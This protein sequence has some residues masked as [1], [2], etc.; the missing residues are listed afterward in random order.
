MTGSGNNRADGAVSSLPL[1][2]RRRGTLE[3]APAP[4]AETGTSVSRPWT[5]VRH[6]E[7]NYVQT[8]ESHHFCAYAGVWRKVYQRIKTK[9]KPHLFGFK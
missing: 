6:A 7:T 8:S 4:P 9:I 1:A 2:S 5:Q 3:A